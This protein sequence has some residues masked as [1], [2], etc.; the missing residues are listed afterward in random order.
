MPYTEDVVGV[1]YSPSD[2]IIIESTAKPGE[3]YSTTKD[4][5]EKKPQ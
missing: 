3:P 2:D 1:N 4:L 5:E